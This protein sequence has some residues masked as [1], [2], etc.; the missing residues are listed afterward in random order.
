[1]PKIAAKEPVYAK[2]QFLRHVES[3]AAWF[4][5]SNADQL[6]PR[7]ALTGATVRQYRK[8]PEKMQVKTLQAYIKLLK[9]NPLT[10]LRYLGF[11][12]KEIN[13]ALRG[14]YEEDSDG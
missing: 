6:G 7:V 1:M 14:E 4:G 2:E 8:N 9:L 5:L 11:T 13:K 3:R 12:Q 10:V